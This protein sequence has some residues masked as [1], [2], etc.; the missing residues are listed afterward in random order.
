MNISIIGLG[1]IGCSMAIDLKKRNFAK[2]IIGVDNNDAH[3]QRA[4]KLDYVDQIKRLDR[5][6][7][8]S[9]IVVLAIPVDA[10]VSLLPK[11]LD[12]VKDQVVTDVCSTKLSLVESVK[13]HPNRSSYIAA[14][15]MAGTENSGPNAA[16]TGL[17]DNKVII[18][19]DTEKSN[20]L[21]LSV[22]ELMFKFLK[23]RPIF[24]DAKSH[25]EHVAYV[26]HIS[27]ISS[28]ALALTVLEKERNEK[29]IFDLASGGFDSTVRLAKSSA[30]M[31]TPIFSN[32]QKNV[33]EV[34]DT[35]IEKLTDFK[36]AIVENKNDKI[37]DMIIQ[38]N[39]IR[40][41]LN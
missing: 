41:I 14:H 2:Q 37:N 15:P 36:N 12:Q 5:A 11:I 29:H 23:M 32:N 8:M 13:K 20:R 7:E 3:A 4:L 1:L 10:A 16:F 18:Y 19:C 35:Y 40:K 21:K 31:W 22:V 33:V 6:I 24:M 39:T 25:D 30:K 34:L 9:D 38:A 26:S 27:H 28:F 17:F